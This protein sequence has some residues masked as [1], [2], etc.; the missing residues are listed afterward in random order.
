MTLFWTNPQLSQQVWPF[1]E[2]WNN[3]DL[4]SQSQK[5]E[6]D[7][8]KV[9]HVLLRIFVDDA[10]CIEKPKPKQILKNLNKSV[11]SQRKQY[12]RAKTGS[13]EDKFVNIESFYMLK[14]IGIRAILCTT[15]RQRCPTTVLNADIH[16]C[17]WKLC[18]RRGLM[19]LF[20][21]ALRTPAE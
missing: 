15:S 2:M 1:L 6:S 16:E 21:E 19:L 7:F 18:D 14:F 10:F 13:V 5:I 8:A 20:Y 4:N 3:V 11:K 9:I 12:L 17:R